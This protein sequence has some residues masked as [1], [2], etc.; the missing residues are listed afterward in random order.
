MHNLLWAASAQHNATATDRH[1]PSPYH[2]CRAHRYL[3]GEDLLL[4]CADV[5]FP[6]CLMMRRML[7]VLLGLSKQ[8]CGW[9]GRWVLWG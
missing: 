2:T 4:I 5:D 6:P 3:A 7:E 8:V 9:V 1:M